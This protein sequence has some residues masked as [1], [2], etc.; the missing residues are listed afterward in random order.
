M[1]GMTKKQFLKK[2]KN[3]LKD[4]G[5]QLLLIREIF[6][7][8]STGKLDFDNDYHKLD[9]IRKNMEN[10]FFKFEGLKPPSKCKSLQREILNTLIILQEVIVV[11]SEYIMLSKDGFTEESQE[12]FKKSIDDL[13]NFRNKFRELSQKI[14]LYLRR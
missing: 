3:C 2:S 6:S 9:K 8:E 5:I 13:E 10:I 11:N 4:T 12:K 1:F 14:D 7:K